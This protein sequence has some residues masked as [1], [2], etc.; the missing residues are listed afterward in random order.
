MT[1]SQI[2][3][4]LGGKTAQYLRINS[5][6]LPKLFDWSLYEPTRHV[7]AW[8]EFCKF[9]CW[10]LQQERYYTISTLSIYFCCAHNNIYSWSMLDFHSNSKIIRCYLSYILCNKYC[11]CSLTYWTN[12]KSGF[13]AR[14]SQYLFHPMPSI[15][16]RRAKPPALMND[17]CVG[18]WCVLLTS[19]FTR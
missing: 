1:H 16:L 10:Y 5:A 11:C 2:L 4:K 15:L 14:F 3:G 6:Y 13:V 17:Y 7:R 18:G 19:T 9:L 8:R 12:Q